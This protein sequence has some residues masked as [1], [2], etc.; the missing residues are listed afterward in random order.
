MVTILVSPT[1][2]FILQGDV[3]PNFEWKFLYELGILVLIAGFMGGIL[4]IPTFIAMGYY[5]VLVSYKKTKLFNKITLSIIGFLGTFLTFGI[6]DSH[7]FSSLDSQMYFPF[8]YAVILVISVWI[9]YP[10]KWN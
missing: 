1:L 3:Q 7:S 8:T 10:K 4:S 5:L 9:F 6:F 2:F